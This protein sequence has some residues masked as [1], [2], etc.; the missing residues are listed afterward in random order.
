MGDLP[1]A[2]RDFQ[3]D[4]HFTL[5]AVIQ[6]VTV[7]ALGNEL[8]VALRALP[9]PG[10]FW[11]FATGMQS[12]LLCIVFWYSF[13]HNYQFGFRVINL[14]A[15][16]HFAFA[17]FYLI[18]GLQQVI[19][20]QFLDVPRIWLTLYVLMIA[21]AFAGTWLSSHVPVIDDKEVQEAMKYD[22]YAKFF[23][24]SFILSVGCVIL[25][26]AVPGIDTLL[27]RAIALS[28]SGVGLVVF[29]IYY[30]LVF[31]RVLELK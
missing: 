26:Y 11:V 28:I 15:K 25:W 19:A 16:T 3:A 31:Q 13:M 10:A 29:A 8:A 4:V 7:A 12:L 20:I 18:L 9:F 23:P 17:A 5:G 22:P 14:N 30:I 6:G 24:V 27:F 2:K 1:E 21:S